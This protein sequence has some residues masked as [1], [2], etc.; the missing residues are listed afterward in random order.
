MKNTLYLLKM[1]FSDLNYPG[2]L[3]LCPDCTLLE[4]V[5]ATN[6]FKGRK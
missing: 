5:L 4:G 1:G 3:F 2:S 6:L